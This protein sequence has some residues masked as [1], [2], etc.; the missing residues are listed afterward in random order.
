MAF[1]RKKDAL[2]TYLLT[3]I[4][5]LNQGKQLLG[6]NVAKVDDKQVQKAIDQI[7]KESPNLVR[8]PP[9]QKAGFNFGG[10]NMLLIGV[11][12]VGLYVFR[13]QL[14]KLVK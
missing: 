4:K 11:A 7:N 13:K 5:S 6:D 3:D 2:S 10:N 9:V 14:K 1:Q 12:L 8:I